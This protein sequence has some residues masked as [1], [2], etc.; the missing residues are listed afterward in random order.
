MTFA[1]VYRQVVGDMNTGISDSLVGFNMVVAVS[2]RKRII[3]PQTYD[4]GWLL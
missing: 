1:R 2:S 4:L 3:L